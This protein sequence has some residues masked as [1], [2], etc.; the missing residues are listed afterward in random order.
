[1]FG[2]SALSILFAA[3]FGA[4]LPLL[5]QPQVY[6]ARPIRV[7][8]S[9]AGGLNDLTARVIGQPLAAALGKQVIVDNR[10]ATAIDIV[11]RAAP[12]G[13]TLLCFA[14]NLWLLPFMQD[15]A[16]FDPIRDFAPLTLAVTAPNVLAIHASVP[17]NSV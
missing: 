11:A 4:A 14:N 1:M 15:K 8:T 5:A 7:V 13:Y 2:R 16:S 6:P 3:A 12:D 17:A 10:G 9:Q